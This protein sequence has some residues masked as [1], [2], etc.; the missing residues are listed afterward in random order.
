M[1]TVIEARD[2]QDTYSEAMG[3]EPVPQ[4]Q[5]TLAEMTELFFEMSNVESFTL[6]NY[7]VHV[8]NHPHYGDIAISQWAGENFATLDI[9]HP[10]PTLGFRPPARCN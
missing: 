1:G 9:R 10:G 5:I 4:G 8:G 2:Y 3:V 6:N 7:L